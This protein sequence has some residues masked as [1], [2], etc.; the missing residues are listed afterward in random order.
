MC[1]SKNLDTIIK[2]H[3]DTYFKEGKKREREKATVYRKTNWRNRNQ[4]VLS[5]DTVGLGGTFTFYL[6]AEFFSVYL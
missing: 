3:Q 2:T 5:L 6:N 4:M 1:K